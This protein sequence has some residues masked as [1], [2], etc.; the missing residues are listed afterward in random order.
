MA[1]YRDFMNK[2][3]IKTEKEVP[4]IVEEEKHEEHHQE[5]NHDHGDHEHTHENEGDLMVTKENLQEYFESEEG[6]EMLNELIREN[7]ADFEAAQEELVQE[8]MDLMKENL[9]E[10]VEELKDHVS[11][12]IKGLNRSMKDR[13]RTQDD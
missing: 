7:N 1:S 2:A 11:N 4:I 8:E 12:E 9:A 6:Q 13:M 10:K 3:A 5:H